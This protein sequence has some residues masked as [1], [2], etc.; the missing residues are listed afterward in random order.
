MGIG[1]GTAALIGGIASAGG[2][3]ASGIIGANGASNAAAAQEAAAKQNQQQLNQA[4]QNALGYQTNQYQ[5]SQQNLAPWLNSGTAAQGQ[6]NNLLGLSAQSP[7]SFASA[8]PVSSAGQSGAS[9]FGQ[10]SGGPSMPTTGQTGGAPGTF[11]RPTAGAV[12]ATP[13]LGSMS[14]PVSSSGPG[15]SVQSSTPSSSSN[16]S[17]PSTGSTPQAGSLLQG[18]GQTFQ[19]PTALT[20]QND[21]GYQARM[22]LG[23]TAM[24]KS[25]A[26]RGNILTG[27][28]AQAE[29]QAAQDYA[30]NEYGN[31]YNR[32][33]N[34]FNTNY[35]VW[36]NDNNNIYNRLMGVSGAGQNA[37]NQSN[38]AGQSAVNGISSNILG[39]AQNVA[40]QG[41]NAAAANASGIVG[42]ANAYGGMATGIGSS[43]N[44]LAQIQSLYGNSGSSV[45][46]STLGSTGYGTLNSSAYAPAA[47]DSSNYYGWNLGG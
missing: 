2:S 32:A 11:G 18:Y 16:S 45:P 25:A 38:L 29:N 46:N 34:N 31:V 28:T 41:S 13:S 23:Q 10:V 3:V 21:P 6:L 8:S 44:N 7:S 14:L 27:G 43:L 39:T 47:G 4:S 30:S 20:E 35:G 26:A 24:E 12:G 9:G 1:S 37:A 19:S 5:Q 36:N 33:L 15:M 40:Q 17:S 22:A 42:Q